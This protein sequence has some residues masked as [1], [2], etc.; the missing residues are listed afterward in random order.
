MRYAVIGDGVAGT[1]AA[2]ALR[3][4]DSSAEVHIFSEEPYPYYRR[5][6]LWEF[7]AG[8]VEQDAIF[9]RP[10][11]WYDEHS[12]ALHLATSV[13]TLAPQEHRLGLADGSTI[14]YDRLL[15]ATGARPF[16]P[17]CMGAELAG[18]FTLRT[19]HDA[20]AIKAYAAQSSTCVVIG[21]GLLGLETARALTTAGLDVTVVEYAPYLLPRQ[22]DSDG[23]AVLQALLE[24]QGLHIICNAQT[25]VILGAGA[26]STIR[27]KDGRTLPADIVLFSTGIRPETS[28]AQTAGI[29]TNR[30]VI[31]D[32][33]LQTSA[34]DVYAA[35]DVA[36]FEGRVY[37]IIPPSIEQARIA[38]A[39]MVNAGS[40]TYAGT[41]PTTTLKIAGAD[42][43]SLGDALEREDTC[44]VLHRSGPTPGQYRRLVVRDGRLIGAVLLNDRKDVRP[45]SQLIERH[46][47]V[48]AHI[49]QLLSD[50]FDLQ[51][52]LL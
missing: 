34:P 41:V 20:L 29:E 9:Y 44:Q 42:L 28:L 14:A 32:R 47:D 10:L 4:A 40:A 25:D 15:L 21:G 23:A 26:A 30:G 49:E 51:R 7:I 17:S 8:Q 22:I 52:L 43:T 46:A 39:N 37:G 24:Q 35:G 16:I 36:E 33:H 11:T 3:N 6:M 38:A 18:V 50:E 19:L 27:L 1:M 31:V 2:Q 12:I 45:V 5:P 13:A 48:S